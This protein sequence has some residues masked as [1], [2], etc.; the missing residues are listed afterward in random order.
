MKN[1]SPSLSSLIGH[2]QPPSTPFEQSRDEIEDL[3]QEAKNWF[4]GEKID[5]E[6]KASAIAKLRN[7]IHA[8]IKRADERRKEENRPFNEGKSIVQARYARLISD[9]Q[10]AKGKAIIAL[11][12]CEKALLPYLKKID[13]DNQERSR[14]LQEEAEKKTSEAQEAIQLRSETI[15]LEERERI[16]SLISEASEARKK[17]KET[18]KN[19]AHISGGNRA[20][21]LRRKLVVTINDEKAF[22][23]YV[24][25]NHRTEMIEFLK[26]TAQRLASAKNRN[27][28]G[29]IIKVEK[30]I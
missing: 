27:L 1:T 18:E 30:T 13:E 19:K 24:L 22:A 3:Y 5:S 8:A 10:T 2:N 26:K 6:P 28:P 29:V 9:T 17:A 20:I 25:N 21:G 14:I 7:L 23:E 12:L 16:E 4:D 11:E 15:D